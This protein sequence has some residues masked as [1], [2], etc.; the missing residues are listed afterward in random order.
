MGLGG[1]EGRWNLGVGNG[2]GGR[3]PIYYRCLSLTLKGGFCRVWPGKYR[4]PQVW[5]MNALNGGSV[6][7]HQYGP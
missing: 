3:R 4:I 1:E 7:R 2:G 5:G 6:L